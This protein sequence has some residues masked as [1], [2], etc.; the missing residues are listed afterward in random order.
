MAD[1]RLG[2]LAA[3]WLLGAM[4]W[5]L[6]LSGP[7]VLERDGVLVGGWVVL[8]AAL[9]AGVA[10]VRPAL[11][12]VPD[13]T[14]IAAAVGGALLLQAFAVGA[15]WPG[16]SDDGLRYRADARAWLAG[17][18][19]YAHTPEE[20]V[21]SG[22]LPDDPLLAHRDVHALYLPTSQGAFVG[23]ELV[24]R[25]VFGDD[26]FGVAGTSPGNPWRSA[27]PTLDP[28]ARLVTWRAAFGACA[29]LATGVLGLVLARRGHP[30]ALAVWF[31]W[32]P[33]VVLESGG[34]GHQ[35]AL[36]ALLLIASVA[37]WE[38]GGAAWTGVL[39]GLSVMVKP[40]GGAV[41]ML[42]L[43]SSGT[44]A[45]ARG[46][47]VAGGL[48]V[49]GVGVCAI[50]FQG[51]HL[52]LLQTA[53][54]FGGS[55][56]A[57][58]ALYPL[59]RASIPAEGPMAQGFKDVWRAGSLLAVVGTLAWLVR[60]RVEP[61]LAGRTLMVVALLLAPVAY[62]WYLVWPLVL[63]PFGPRLPWGLA[64]WSSTVGVSYL[65][66]RTPDWV[67][68]WPAWAFEYVPVLIGLAADLVST[69]ASERDAR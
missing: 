43:A 67:L 59:G 38:R 1:A 45:R 39:A 48:A 28:P 60:A 21:R 49:G 11:A 29:V 63:V 14:Q 65:L 23:I 44:G 66:W 61:V 27:L 51:G 7:G 55:W 54:L 25:S 32:H 46:L 64:A 26:R 16:L 56:E 24:D 15:L 42:W 10:W 2:G 8:S 57:N 47:L 62:P 34:M 35:D 53:S 20:L 18:S 33:L 12:G 19:P 31:G 9:F 58:G 13:R 30:P 22:A 3:V 6:A 36:G 17:R 37:L 5:M 68:P 69:R 41:A 50:A 4:A 52:G 40:L